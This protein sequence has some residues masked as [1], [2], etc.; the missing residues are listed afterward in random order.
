MN[1]W[2]AL[3]KDRKSKAEKLGLDMSFVG[4]IYNL[5]H[6]ESIRVQSEIM[7]KK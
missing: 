3:L 1:R 2:D 7:N 6:K 5:I 4:D